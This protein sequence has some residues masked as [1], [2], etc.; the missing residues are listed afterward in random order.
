MESED[1]VTD[2]VVLYVRFARPFYR[3]YVC[4]QW[5]LKREIRQ[6]REVLAAFRLSGRCTAMG[7]MESRRSSR[8]AAAIHFCW[9]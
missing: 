7:S 2:E 6:D 4:Q 8:G 9:R 5:W 1:D 3:H